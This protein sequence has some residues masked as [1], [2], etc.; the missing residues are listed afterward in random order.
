MSDFVTGPTSKW[1]TSNLTFS[2]SY[3]SNMFNMASSVPFT[4]VLI[5]TDSMWFIALLIV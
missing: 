4:S 2:Q 3:L 1:T 5:I